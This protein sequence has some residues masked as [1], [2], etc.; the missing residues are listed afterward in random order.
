MVVVAV[1]V[2]VVV[3]CVCVAQDVK[4]P[5]CARVCGG[6]SCAVV[7][8]PFFSILSLSRCF[9]KRLDYDTVESERDTLDR[10]SCVCVFARAHPCV[11]HPTCAPPSRPPISFAHSSV[12]CPSDFIYFPSH[13]HTAIRV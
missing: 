4:E 5:L 3:V 2:V 13:Y 7:S 1:V 6:S 11:R 9:A 12:S 10:C 8:S